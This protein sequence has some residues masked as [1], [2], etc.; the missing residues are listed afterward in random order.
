MRV[1]ADHVFVVFMAVVGVAAGV[2]AIVEPSITARIPVFL[3]ILIAMACYEGIRMLV[4][5]GQ[6]DALMR[7]EMRLLGFGLAV[8]IAILLP[9]LAGASAASV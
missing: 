4:K 5:R 2:V 1:N 7:M 8:A 9:W 6:P 3:L